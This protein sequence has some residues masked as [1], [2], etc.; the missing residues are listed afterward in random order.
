MITHPCV[1]WVNGNLATYFLRIVYI[2][3]FDFLKR[4]AQFVTG[5][6]SSLVWLCLKT[7]YPQIQWFYWWFCPSK[8]QFYW[9]SPPNMDTPISYLCFVPVSLSMYFD[10]PIFGHVAIMSIHAHY[11]FVKSILVCLLQIS[12][13]WT[14]PIW[15]LVKHQVLVVLV[16]RGHFKFKQGVNNVEP[17]RCEG[18]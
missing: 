12:S 2:Y 17:C 7:V 15:A 5:E 9:V 13:G 10:I 8:W 11:S 14:T 4:N 3:F 18:L 1:Y 6:L 16:K